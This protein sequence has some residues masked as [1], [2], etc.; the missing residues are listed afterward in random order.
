MSKPVN[1]DSTS[2]NPIVDGLTPESNPCDEALI[3]R[4]RQRYL[5]S[6]SSELAEKND[7]Q[8]SEQ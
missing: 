3:S 1:M 6:L 5:A 2:T 7:N 8:Y 4:Q